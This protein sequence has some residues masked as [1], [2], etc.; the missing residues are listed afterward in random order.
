MPWYF[1]LAIVIAYLAICVCIGKG[2]KRNGE[3]YAERPEELH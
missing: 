2:L 3:H 1:W